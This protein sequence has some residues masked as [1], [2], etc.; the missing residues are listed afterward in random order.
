M[1]C[2]RVTHNEIV[3]LVS[4]TARQHINTTT[5]SI[6]LVDLI[7]VLSPHADQRLRVTAEGWLSW[8]RGASVS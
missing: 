1:M 2:E 7:R 6:R 4:N 8:R 5:Q 3:L